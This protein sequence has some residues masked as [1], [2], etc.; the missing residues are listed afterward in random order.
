[1]CI[2]SPL[3]FFNHHARQK[4]LP[5]SGYLVCELDEGIKNFNTSPRFE[6][7]LANSAKGARRARFFLIHRS[8]S[9]PP[10]PLLFLLL[11]S[12]GDFHRDSSI[13]GKSRSTYRVV[14]S[15]PRIFFARLSDT[16][17]DLSM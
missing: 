1:M 14:K 17:S 9:P 3:I 13:N 5:S 11:W 4:P 10:L 6:K 2:I 7:T 12:R 15:S 16:C 8:L